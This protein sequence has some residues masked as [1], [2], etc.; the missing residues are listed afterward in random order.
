MDAG[1]LSILREFERAERAAPQRHYE[2]A[3]DAIVTA[4]SG[5]WLRKGYEM[6]HLCP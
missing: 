5:Y 2:C 4:N 6:G 3:V 1:A